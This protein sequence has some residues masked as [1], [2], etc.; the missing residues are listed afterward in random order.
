LSLIAVAVSMS[1]VTR[2]LD[3]YA[4][5][6]YPIHPAR[7]FSAELARLPIGKAGRSASLAERELIIESAFRHGETL[8]QVLDQLGLDR[9]DAWALS[10]E[11]A[12]HADLRR[13]RPSDSYGV[14][15]GAERRVSAFR[16]TLAGRGRVE[17]RRHGEAWQGVWQPFVELRK[18]RSIRGELKG[19]LEES[20]RQ[21]GA[22]ATVAYLM[23]DVLQWDL[24]FTRDL[25]EGDRF[26]ILFEEIFLDDAYESAGEI[27]ALTYENRG[28]RLE[29]YRFGDDQG[30][31]DAEGR[32][33]RKMFLRSPLRF[34]RITSRFSRRRLHPILKRYRPHYGVDYGAPSGTPVRVT[35]NGVVVFTGWDG[36][37]GRTVKVRHPNQYLT[38]YLHLSRYASGI[39][40]GRRVQQGEIIGYVGSTGLANGPH[41]DYRIQHRGSWINPLSLKSEPAEPIPED[42]LPEF[43]EQRNRLRQRLAPVTPAAPALEAAAGR[44]AAVRS[45][46]SPSPT[47]GQ[48]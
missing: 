15:R 5:S 31:Y 27:L 16:L 43:L 28:R 36:G 6:P 24:D 39:R 13:L 46:E 48:R 23:A 1:L 10:Q 4:K 11:L 12:R 41:L 21:A 3:A 25:R 7:P 35:G 33:L 2:R 26:E 37:G 14:L 47:T 42:Q 17:T 20:V 38:A 8:S 19:F 32:P 34:S 18:E 40:R 29:A 9:E 45:V 44:V 30:Y 22:E